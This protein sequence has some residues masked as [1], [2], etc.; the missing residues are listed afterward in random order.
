MNQVVALLQKFGLLPGP[1]SGSTSNGKRQLDSGETT[2]KTLDKAE[3]SKSLL[4]KFALD[5][6]HSEASPDEDVLPQRRPSVIAYQTL[7]LQE[8][9]RNLLTKRHPRMAEILDNLDRRP[10][11]DDR[12]DET[13][14]MMQRLSSILKGFALEFNTLTIDIP[15]FDAMRLS[16]SEVSDVKEQ[17]APKPYGV[18]SKGATRPQTTKTRTY[19]RFRI[20]TQS[21]CLSIRGYRGRIEFYLLTA[22]DVF[23][24]S[25]SETPVRLRS[26]LML[27]DRLGMDIWMIDSL[28]ADPDEVFYVCRSLFRN[29]LFA[30]AEDVKEEL[31]TAAVLQTLEGDALKTTVREL[32]LAGQ[33][34]AQKIVS[35]QEEIQNR[36]ARD[37]HDT[38]ISDLMALK[39]SLAGDAELSEEQLNSSLETIC[40]NIREICHDL[41]PRDLKDWGLQTVVEDMLERVAQRTGADCSF[42]CETE[43]PEFPYPVQ[44]HLFR[45]IQECLN[46]IEKYAKASRIL[47][48]FDVEEQT[49]KLSMRDD[50]RGFA[51][52]EIEAKR[53][54]E[55]GTGMSGIRERAEMIRCFYP[56]KLKFESAPGKG[57]VT[58]LEMR[59]N[60]S[61]WAPRD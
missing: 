16:F 40:Q 44:L 53:A 43:L 29:L 34:M 59:L 2:D 45:I 26:V 27:N 30:S 58:T 51:V 55:G 25:Q 31:D 36:I 47:V 33:N 41:T 14:R 1:D 5:D 11:T 7:W 23:V 38:V 12:Q 61:N 42:E 22:T 56:T 18:V 50:G 49:V 13:R 57:S 39:R 10:A 48:K 60:E 32:L 52:T 3:H 28:P 35:Q 24:L 46:N 17:D 21:W 8:L 37:L 20:A 6:A 9:V 54:R 15:G 19:T 4:E